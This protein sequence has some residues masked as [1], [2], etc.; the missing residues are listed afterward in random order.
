MVQKMG[1]ADPLW[2]GRWGCN[3]TL[4]SLQFNACQVPGTEGTE[5]DALLASGDGERPTTPNTVCV[6][7]GPETRIYPP[8][9]TVTPLLR[10]R[11]PRSTGVQ[12]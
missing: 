8:T 12:I 3:T 5:W 1:P 6:R 2:C 10:Q 4:C 7:S 11:R 9:P